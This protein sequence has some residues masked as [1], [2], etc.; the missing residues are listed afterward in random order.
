MNAES[1]QGEIMAIFKRA[2]FVTILSVPLF[3]I[4][5]SNTTFEQKPFRFDKEQADKDFIGNFE[6]RYKRNVGIKS[7]GKFE[8]LPGLEVTINERQ[9][10]YPKGSLTIKLTG[11]RA[12]YQR[13]LF[14]RKLKKNRYLVSVPVIAKKDREKMEWNPK[15]VSGYKVALVEKFKMGWK[16]RFIN[17]EFFNRKIKNKDLK[18]KIKQARDDSNIAREA[19]FEDV[20]VSESTNK[21]DSFFN[22]IPLKSVFSDPAAELRKRNLSSK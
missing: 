14:V 9:P 21:L 7:S 13:P 10:N 22:Q 17:D 20:V 2:F 15:S 5:C 12:N 1:H 16:L 6:I 18:G 4:G 3:L 8:R 19:I 11:R